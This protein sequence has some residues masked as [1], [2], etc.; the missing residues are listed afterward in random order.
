MLS[1]TKSFWS[2]IAEAQN[3]GLIINQN[4]PGD[5]VGAALALAAAISQRGQAVEVL[6]SPSERGSLYSFL[7]GF[8]DIQTNPQKYSYPYLDIPLV[9]LNLEDV[10]LEQLPDRLRLSFK[11]SALPLNDTTLKIAEPQSA[12][13]LLIT[14]G[15]PDP[16][17]FCLLQQN[18]SQL[19]ANTPLI[20]ID[21][22]CA[23]ENFG[24]L[25]IIDIQAAAV[26]EI[27]ATLINAVQQPLNSNIATCLLCGLMVASRNFKS[28]LVRPATLT[29]ASQLVKQGANRELIVDKLYRNRSLSLLKLWGQILNNLQTEV[30][31]QVYYSQVS[32]T[33]WQEAGG[34]QDNLMML[35]EELVATLPNAHLFVLII[36]QGLNCQLQFYAFKNI[37]ILQLA[38]SYQPQGNR[39]MAS[40]QLTAEQS[41]TALAEIAERLRKIVDN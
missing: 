11:K 3:I 31:Q 22:N 2:I 4:W 19:F 10:Q 12:F 16:D 36:Q 9:G 15:C 32:A 5:A 23:N 37:D 8:N 34:N 7:P 41:K 33:A 28:P 35:A 39:K 14:L 30:G 27:V 26:S 20:N 13:D 18:Q 40:C 25:N 24:Q 1:D 38:A 29:L 21:N 17:A 6:A